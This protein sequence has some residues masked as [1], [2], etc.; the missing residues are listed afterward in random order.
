MIKSS[1]WVA[2]QIGR[3]SVAPARNDRHNVKEDAVAAPRS[4]RAQKLDLRLSPEAIATISAAAA[5]THRPVSEFVVESALAQAEEALADR[6]H[7]GL[8]AEQWEQ[9]LAAL[10]APPREL[11]R[12]DKRLHKPGVFDNREPS[13][14]RCDERESNDSKA[15][16]A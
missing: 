2:L 10:D 11:P 9:F 12:L 4:T 8:N 6:R 14:L 1:V 13:R 7:F 3:D 15:D 5:A 16:I